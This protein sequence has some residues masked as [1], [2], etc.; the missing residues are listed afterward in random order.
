M[1]NVEELWDD[2]SWR[3][4]PSARE[5]RESSTAFLEQSRDRG[6]QNWTRIDALMRD[7]G[8]K[9]PADPDRRSI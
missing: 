1:C 2:D 4:R 7:L 9:R 6:E 5:L 8:L 3:L